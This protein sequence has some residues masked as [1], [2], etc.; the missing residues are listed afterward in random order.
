MNSD[1]T[2]AAPLSLPPHVQLIQMG[3]GGWV[4]AVVYHAAKMKLADHLTEGPKDAAQAFSARARAAGSR[5][6]RWARRCGPMR[7]ARRGRR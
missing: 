2:T 6:R 3:I 5:S 1:L 7:R 4:S